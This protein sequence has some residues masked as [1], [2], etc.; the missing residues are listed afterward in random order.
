MKTRR[1]HL[2]VAGFPKKGITEG[3]P[4][5]GKAEPCRIV[6]GETPEASPTLPGI[7][8]HADSTLNFY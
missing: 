7:S 4:L 5:P 8:R 2:M 3:N 1:V 6:A